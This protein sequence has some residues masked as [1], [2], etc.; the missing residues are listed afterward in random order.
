MP[1]L[2]VP[3]LAVSNNIALAVN[4]KIAVF[5]QGA[6]RVYL[7]GPY[8]NAPNVDALVVDKVANAAEY[9]SAAV[10]VATNYYIDAYGGQPVY[11]EVGT[12]AIVKQNRVLSGIQTDPVALN[13]TGAITAAAI[14]G[15]ILTSTT[16]AAV[17]GTLPTG[18]VM[19]AC[20]EWLVNEFVDWAVIATGANALT[21][22][23]TLGHT[24]V[25]GSGAAIVCPT[26]TSTLMRTR[27]TAV[28]T[29]V[30]YA[31]SCPVS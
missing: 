25:G 1:S 4:D 31:I 23:A 13:A 14:L 10:S 12:D 5:S 8:V 9:V 22:T 2:L 21:V 16:G 30:T 19:E 20:A 17:A 3:P 7:S 29:F 11:Y 18:A 15:G 27:K 28:D 24:V 26:L 6:F